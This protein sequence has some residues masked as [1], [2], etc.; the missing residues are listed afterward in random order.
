MDRRQ[1][2]TVVAAAVA[3]GC[4]LGLGPGTSGSSLGTAI[5]ADQAAKVAQGLS[6]PSTLSSTPQLIDMVTARAKYLGANYHDPQVP[7][8]EKFFVV[9]LD[10][11]G[12]GCSG[13]GVPLPASAPGH[14]APS[15]FSHTTY[16]I[17]QDGGRVVGTV[18]KPCAQ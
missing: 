3:A 1:A 2:F 14:P 12:S 17:T 6:G 10:A 4:G 11:A 7:E 13:M 8:T 16:I 9:D 5:T 15:G 18:S